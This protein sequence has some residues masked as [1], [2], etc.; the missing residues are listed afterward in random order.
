[1]ALLNVEIILTIVCLVAVDWS[2]SRTA[3]CA[4][5][6]QF[7]SRFDGCCQAN[8]VC[9]THNGYTDFSESTFCTN[10]QSKVNAGPKLASGVRCNDSIECRD[11]CCRE[12]KAVRQMSRTCGV[13]E[14]YRTPPVIYYNCITSRPK[15][16]FVG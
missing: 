11:K 6:G 8:E 12:E 9:L 1:M 16:F 5:T 14:D 13:P 15:S 2:E 3:Q 10:L 7:C 4:Q